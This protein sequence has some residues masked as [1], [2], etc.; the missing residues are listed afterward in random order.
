MAAVKIIFMPLSIWYTL[1]ATIVSAMFIK[2][3]AM[4]SREAGMA[5]RSGLMS[6]LSLVESL[7]AMLLADSETTSG[8]PY[9]RR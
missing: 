6:V 5:S 4:M 8:S 3:E 9:L 7:F 1:A 2:V